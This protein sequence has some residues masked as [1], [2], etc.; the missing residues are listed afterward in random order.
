MTV[1]LRIGLVIIAIVSIA[2][3]GSQFIVPLSVKCESSPSWQGSAPHGA[4]W[5]KET[6]HWDHVPAGY[7]TLV[8]WV[9]AA[10]TV[11]CADEST[12]TPRVEIRLVRIIAR[13]AA[14]TETILT[15]IDP[16]NQETF[17]G[18]LFPRVPKW[19]GET[20]GRNEKN[21]V[22]ISDDRLS[23]DLGAVPLRVYHGWT[24]PR[25][26]IDPTSQYFLEIEA[27]ITETARLQ[28]GIDYWRDLG[29]DYAGWDATCERSANCEGWVSNWYGNTYGEFQTFRAPQ[30]PPQTDDAHE[31]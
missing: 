4:I 21:I 9:N 28:F 30:Y 6:I 29:S 23:L 12:V 8:G 13:D 11:P 24:E 3:V 26:W 25:I 16:R 2:Y 15:E 14:G 19:F 1:I 5:E 22:T 10:T 31:N 17:V 27:N 18:R 20:E 7:F